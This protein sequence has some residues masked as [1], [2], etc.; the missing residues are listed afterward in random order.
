MIVCFGALF[1]FLIFLRQEDDYYAALI[2]AIIFNKDIPCCFL[3]IKFRLSNFAI[4]MYY[5]SVAHSVFN[6][7]RTK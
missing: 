4:V 3:L 1:H 2:A 7:P 5:T 6:M